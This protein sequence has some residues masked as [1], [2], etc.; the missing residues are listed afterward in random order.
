MTSNGHQK[1]NPFIHILM[2]EINWK[3]TGKDKMGV[4]L[5]PKKKDKMV[6]FEKILFYLII[7]ET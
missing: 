1:T 3:Y 5:Y 4:F 6:V 2:G 7:K